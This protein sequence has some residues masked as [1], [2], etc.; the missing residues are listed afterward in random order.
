MTALLLPQDRASLLALYRGLAESNMGLRRQAQQ[1]LV[2][3][4]AVKRLYVAARSETA[5]F[6]WRHYALS[7]ELFGPPQ[8]TA[9]PVAEIPR[10]LIDGFTLGGRVPIERNYL[11]ATYP[12]NWPL[13][14]ADY[15][16][17][18][19]LAQIAC[20]EPFVYGQT[21]LWMWEALEKYP[22]RGLDVVH[23]GSLTPWYEATSLYHGARSTT[24]DYNPILALSDRVRTMTIAQWDADRPT[25]D[26]AWSISSFEHDGLG[27]YG[28]PLDPEGDLKAMRKMRQIVKPG[29]LLFLAVP[30]GSDKLRFNEARIYGRIRLPMLIEGWEQIDQ[31]GLHPDLLDGPGHAQPILVLRN[32]R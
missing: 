16:I 7:R 23:M 21:D 28:D 19:Y 32:I 12:A 11:D 18:V 30:V 3:L 26:V 5:S 6:L 20:G 24:I 8:P 17:D 1:E 27:M 9:R 31:F 4:R 13:I 14:Y 29:G 15:E 25:F 22:V 10:E 2:R